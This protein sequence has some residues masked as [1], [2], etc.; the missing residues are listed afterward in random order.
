VTAERVSASEQG[1]ANPSRLIYSQLIRRPRR[2]L[3]RWVEASLAA[4]TNTGHAQ[5]QKAQ[6]I[7][8]HGLR[9]QN[10][11]ADASCAF[12]TSEAR[13]AKSRAYQYPAPKRLVLG[14]DAYAML[15]K[16]LTARLAD[17]LGQQVVAYSTDVGPEI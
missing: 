11:V 13:C 14:S 15:E 7:V 17:V 6:V 9:P 2:C 1:L 16:A 10:W 3:V 4:D 8:C 5:G 12:S